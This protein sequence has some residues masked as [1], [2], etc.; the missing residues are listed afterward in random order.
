[1]PRWVAILATSIFFG[2]VHVGWGEHL[3]GL[4]SAFPL[5]ILATIFCLAY[6]RT[7]SIGTTIV[8][9]SLFNLNM[10]LLILA[11]FGS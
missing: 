1:M 10:T 7:G 11:G 3:A 2:L 6:E 9:H 4:V 5:V 8:A